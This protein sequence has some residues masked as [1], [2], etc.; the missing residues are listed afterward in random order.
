VDQFTT[1]EI[2]KSLKSDD[3]TNVQAFYRLDSYFSS[4]IYQVQTMAF[5]FQND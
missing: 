2:E 5:G 3:Q 1:P 4:V